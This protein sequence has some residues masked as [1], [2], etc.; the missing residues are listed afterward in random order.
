MNKR[1][2][3]AIIVGIGGH[4]HVWK[5]ALNQHP[6][7]VLAAIVDTDTDKLEHAP[8]SWG[9]D[10]NEAFTNVEEAIQFG[11]GPYDL[12]I[13]VTPT[14][15]HHVLAMECLEVDLNVISEKNLA[16]SINQGRQMVKAANEHPH[17]CTAAGTQTRYFPQN[18]SLKKYYLE[19]KKTL[20]KVTSLNFSFLYNWGKTRQ[21]W[22]RWLK[23]LFLE[24]MAPHHFDLMRYLTDMDIVQVQGAVNFKPSFSY[25]KGSSTTFAIFALSTPE[26]YDNPDNWIYATYRGDWQKKGKLQHKVEI[27]YEGGELNLIEKNKEKMITVS[28]F[29]DPEGFQYHDEPVPI[30]KDVEYNTNNYSS[31]LFLLNEMSIGI[32]SKGKIQPKTNYR[33]A[34]KSF[35]VSQGIV[36]SFETGKSVF[37][38]KYW[39]NLNIN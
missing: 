22:R 37:L 13:I 3:R 17:L 16:S 6:D 27:N 1:V 19:N 29:D 25:F 11:K 38:P 26:N 8:Q 9:V 10:R 34:F 5:K 18:W 14:Y 23:D 20:G 35:A 24:D 28:I 15:T 4:A 7:W 36:E 33:D 21:G 30:S 32:D 12:A 31:E 39:K 2:K